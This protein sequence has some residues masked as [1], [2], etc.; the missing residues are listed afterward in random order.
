[1]APAAKFPHEVTFIIPR[2]GDRFPEGKYVPLDLDRVSDMHGRLGDLLHPKSGVPFGVWDHQWYRDTR[3][4][5]RGA[6]K[7]LWPIVKESKPYFYYKDLP[8]FEM[9]ASNDGNGNDDV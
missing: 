5:L 4:F 1:M 3:D 2:T 6:L 9:H 8:I 7:Y